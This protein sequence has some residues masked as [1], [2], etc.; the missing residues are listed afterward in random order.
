[1]KA[2]LHQSLRYFHVSPRFGGQLQSS[3]QSDRVNHCIKYDST[4]MQDYIAVYACKIA[5]CVKQV[6]RDRVEETE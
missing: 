4:C 6:R 5:E 3:L 1:M 2:D